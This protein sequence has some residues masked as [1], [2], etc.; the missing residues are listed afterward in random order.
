MV[1]RKYEMS[2]FPWSLESSD[3]GDSSYLNDSLEIPVVWME[4][5]FVTLRIL[6]NS[7]LD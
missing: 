5:S 2:P 7:Q 1:Y 4:T 3:H 6:V